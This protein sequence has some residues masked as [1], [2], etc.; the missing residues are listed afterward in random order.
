MAEA[1]KLPSGM[2]R[3]QVRVKGFKAVSITRRTKKECDEAA[4]QMEADMRAGRTGKFPNTTLEQLF[5][6]YSREV[7]PKKVGVRTE[8]TRIEAYKRMFV[9][10]PGYGDML[11]RP[12]YEFEKC[13]F[14]AWR[15][16]RLSQVSE[17]SVRRD[18]VL[19]RNILRLARLEW[20][21]TDKN[22]FEGVRLPR[23]NPA[24]TRRASWMEIKRIVRD[25]GYRTGEAPSTK[26]QQIACMFLLALRTG[27]RTTE[28]LRLTD[29]NTDLVKR[30]VKIKRKTYHATRAIREVPLTSAAARLLRPL[31]GWGGPLFTVKRD[32]CDDVFRA[33]SQRCRVEG[34][35]FR[36]SRATAATFLARSKRFKVDVLT[37]AKI[38]D[39]KDL[40]QLNRTYYREEA[41]EIAKRIG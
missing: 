1:E 14:V 25:L 41:A 26:P 35:Q 11:H 16:M 24:R 30:V 10:L 29:E 38:L 17:G 28:L 2:W 34:L 23:D 9:N 12:V 32:R 21:M 18:V 4:V 15:D 6:K 8:Q 33:A 27:L 3:R 20:G 13:H 5:D 40:D 22:P 19:L 39:H 36:D 7:S 31:K 37:L